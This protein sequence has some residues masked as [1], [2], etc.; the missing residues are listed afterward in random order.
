MFSFPTQLVSHKYYQL[1]DINSKSTTKDIFEAI[2]KLY[3]EYH[4]TQFNIDIL[5]CFTTLKGKDGHTRPTSQLQGIK[6]NK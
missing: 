1:L 3:H 6:K 4:K 5:F 2:K